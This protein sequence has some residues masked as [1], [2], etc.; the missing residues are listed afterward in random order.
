MLEGRDS[1]ADALAITHWMAY[2]ATVQGNTASTVRGKVSALRWFHAMADDCIQLP[3]HPH[4]TRTLAGIAKISAPPAPKSPLFLADIIAGWSIAATMGGRTLTVWRGVMLSF[5]LLLRGS[6]IWAY[7]SGLSDTDFCL[8]FNG[9]QF[10]RGGLQ[11]TVHER[12]TADAAT[13]TLRGSKTDQTRVGST[14]VLHRS[15]SAWHD[16]IA[17]LLSLFDSMPAEHLSNAMAPQ[18]HVPLMTVPPASRG[19]RGAVVTRDEAASFIKTLAR[20]R[21][22]DSTCYSTHSMRVVGA[23]TLAQAGLDPH[24]IK[25]AGR[26][27]SDAYLT[28]IRPSMTQHGR[29]AAALT[30]TATTGVVPRPRR[31]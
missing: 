16:P 2:L 27:R 11:V 12:H 25:L 5:H 15:S 20:M 26:W 1:N 14:L 10:L 22:Y 6:E 23:C 19:M 9:V 24:H 30:Q 29:I 17:V 31:H 13:I 4:I 8:L 7:L 18:S 28:Y 21:G 3:Q